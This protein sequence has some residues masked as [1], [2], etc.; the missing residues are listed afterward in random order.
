MSLWTILRHSWRAFWTIFV[1]W[2]ICGYTRNILLSM[3]L[4]LYPP[5]RL[6][7]LGSIEASRSSLALNE[8]GCS[9][10]L[11]HLEA[12]HQSMTISPSGIIPIIYCCFLFSIASCF[13]SFR[14]C[15]SASLHSWLLTSGIANSLLQLKCKSWKLMHT[16]KF[17]LFHSKI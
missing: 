14:K 6:S 3:G 10:R 9:Y 7:F 13:L 8:K 1:H 11:G 15:W 2:H 12:W 4:D 5:I 16:L 17:L